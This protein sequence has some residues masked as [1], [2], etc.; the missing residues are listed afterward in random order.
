LRPNSLKPFSKEPARK[1]VEFSAFSRPQR[2]KPKSCDS[3]DFNYI[4]S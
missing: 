2:L 3:Y 4:N 1:D